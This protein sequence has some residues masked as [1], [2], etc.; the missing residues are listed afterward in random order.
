M[1]TEVTRK[2]PPLFTQV[3]GSL[4]RPRV[5]QALHAKR[6]ETPPE[7]FQTVMDEMVLFAIRLQEE[8]GLDVVSDGEWRRIQY[9]DEFLYRIGGFEKIRPFEHAGEKKF[10]LVA[11]RRMEAVEPVFRSDA[12]FLARHTDR[13]KKFALPSPFLVA[14][15]YWHPDFSTD[16][17]PTVES[18][19]EH[20]SQILAREARALVE[21]GIDIIQLDDPALTYFCDRQLMNEGATHDDRLRQHWDPRK[22]VPETVSY[23]NHIVDGLKAEVHLHCCHS[24]Y[25]RQSDVTGNYEPL[26]PL[27][28]DI[29]VDR[30]NLEFAYHGTGDISDLTLL[31]EG[32]DVGMGVIDVRSERLQT[33]D[34]VAALATAGAE[35]IGAHRVALNPD[36]GFAPD[37]GEPPTI[38]EAFEKLC[39]LSA[40]ARQVR[41]TVGTARPS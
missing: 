27:L 35:A 6:K 4:P 28:G 38:D 41:E 29:R 26:L 8:A 11:T 39:R 37:M 25:K 18:F 1:K 3:I 16:A 40:A 24:V 36:C 12:E 19:M 7:R 15:R 9:V 17:Y 23:I 2:L 13:V 31:P 33:V 32:I 14:I 30:L 5:V 34:E 10:H 20:L 21:A 22:Q